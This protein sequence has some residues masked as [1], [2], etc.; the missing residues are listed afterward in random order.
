MTS[1]TRAAAA[2]RAGYLG[3]PPS[4]AAELTADS[5]ADSSVRIWLTMA[6]GN[7]DPPISMVVRTRR[8]AS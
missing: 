8:A 6:G 3:P 4:A 1:T 5:T 7:R 2:G